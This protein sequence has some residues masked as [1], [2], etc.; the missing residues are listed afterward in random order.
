MQS[1]VISHL[2]YYSVLQDASMGLKARLQRLSNSAIRYIF[3]VGG[4]TRI[5]PF[6]SKLG[7]F[8]VVSMHYFSLLTMYKIVHMREP[9][10]LL[11]LF[12]NYKPGR[13]TRGARIDLDVPK[14]EG[15]FPHSVCG[16]HTYGTPFSQKFVIWH[17]FHPL[18]GR[19]EGIS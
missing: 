5:S 17:P 16:V 14:N 10:I 2:D 3:G 12:Q 11:K 6:R 7:W 15:D 9:P 19:S 1:L 4:L 8:R 13:P 18:R